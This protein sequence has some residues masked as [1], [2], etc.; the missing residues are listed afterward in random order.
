[1]RNHFRKLIAI[2]ALLTVT[3]VLPAVTESVSACPSCKAANETDSRRPKAYMYSILFMLGMPATVFAGFGI[4]FYRMSRRAMSE[5]M[6]L[7][8]QEQRPDADVPQNDGSPT[9]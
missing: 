6:E 7:A 4:S 5:Q 1:M 9:T 8:L 3:G 2:V